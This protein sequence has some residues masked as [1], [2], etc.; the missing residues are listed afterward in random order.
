M[1]T[2]DAIAVVLVLIG[3]LNWGLVGV[4]GFDLV[5]ALFGLRFGETSAISSVVYALVGLAGVYQALFWRSIRQRWH[6][7][8]QTARAH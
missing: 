6:S 3:A 4:A 1:R 2:L 5:A 7:Q 8:T